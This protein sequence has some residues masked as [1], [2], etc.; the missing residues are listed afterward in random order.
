MRRSHSVMRWLGSVAA[1]TLSLVW[2]H[3]LGAGDLTAPPLSMSGTTAWLDHRDTITAA[4]A[5]LRVIA[6]GFGSY[7]LLITTVAGGAHYLRLSRISS[8]VDRITL[9]F[10]KGMLGSMA[11][12]GVLAAPPAPTPPTVQPPIR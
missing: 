2:L 11:L 1:I 5:L 6:I 3:R 8:A 9:P 7:L 12:L 4:F 10:A